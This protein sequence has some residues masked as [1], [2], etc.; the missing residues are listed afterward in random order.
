MNVWALGHH[1]LRKLFYAYFVGEENRNE[2]AQYFQKNVGIP[3]VCLGRLGSKCKT[4]WAFK[5]QNSITLMEN[6]GLLKM[7]ESLQTNFGF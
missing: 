5:K 2:N 3:F 6:N 4:E 1:T 7:A